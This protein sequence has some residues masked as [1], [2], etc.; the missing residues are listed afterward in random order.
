M[1]V[2]PAGGGL[3]S[4]AGSWPQMPKSSSNCAATRAPVSS[5]CFCLMNVV[6]PHCMAPF[7]LFTPGLLPLSSIH[8]HVAGREG[9]FVWI[10]SHLQRS[11]SLLYLHDTCRE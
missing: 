4:G 6:R 3:R 2:V 9:L 8:L 5:I 7:S 10:V 1:T 11:I